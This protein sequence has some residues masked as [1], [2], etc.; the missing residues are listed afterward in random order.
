MAV[1]REVAD[2]YGIRFLDAC[3][4]GVAY[5]T[6]FSRCFLGDARAP[7]PSRGSEQWLH[8]GRTDRRTRHYLIART[9][10]AKRITGGAERLDRTSSLAT[11]TSGLRSVMRR[12]ADAGL[13]P[14]PGPVWK[15]RDQQTGL[16]RQIAVERVWRQGPR[17]ARPPPL[18]ETSR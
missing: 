17:G 2:S 1:C 10:Q 14:L 4:Q 13:G 18:R 16:H 12:R 8:S 5:A 9:A 11:S 3:F 6:G 15:Y 7:R